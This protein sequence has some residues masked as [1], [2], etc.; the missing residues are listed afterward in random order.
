[1]FVWKHRHDEILPSGIHEDATSREKKKTHLE[2]LEHQA[3]IRIA[4]R[5]N[6]ETIMIDYAND[7]LGLKRSDKQPIS[8]FAELNRALKK[9]KKEPEKNRYL[10]SYIN[11]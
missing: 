6:V 7:T 2:L 11:I 3:E 5:R 10:N 1:M 8:T 9:L 4:A